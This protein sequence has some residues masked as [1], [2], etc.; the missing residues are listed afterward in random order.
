MNE[1][2]RRFKLGKLAL[3]V[4]LTCMLQGCPNSAPDKLLELRATLDHWEENLEQRFEKTPQELEI[5]TGYAEVELSGD[6]A[7]VYPV[8]VER[9][10]V[11]SEME[12][13]LVR[14]N[15]QWRIVSGG[16]RS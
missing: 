13:T 5:E 16:S 11:S 6:I 10:Y 1:R 8:F 7:R 12:L 3:L 2:V 9:R 15:G 4:G 14:Y